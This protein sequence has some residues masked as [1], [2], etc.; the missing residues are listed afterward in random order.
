MKKFTIIAAALFIG[1]SANAQQATTKAP[2]QETA[3]PQPKDITKV[4]EFK[5]ADY[6]FGKIPFG[7]PAEYELLIKNISHDSVTLDRVQVGCGCTTPKYEA[8]KKFGPGETVKVTLGFNGGTDGAFT[9]TVTIYFSDNMSKVVTFK[10]ETYKT[11]D[12]S[13]PANGGVEKMKT[14]GS[15]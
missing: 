15:K 3:Q 2:A 10:G 9:K 14:G 5:N 1:F 12:T 4:L 13:A 8:N 6:D 7:K 11:P